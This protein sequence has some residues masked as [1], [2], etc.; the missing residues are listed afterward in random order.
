VLTPG[1][2][3]TVP[4]PTT[5]PLRGIGF[6][7]TGNVPTSLYQLDPNS[8]VNVVIR[9]QNGRQLASSS[10]LTAGVT[11]DTAFQVAL[12]GESI[13]AGTQE[14]ATI[15][16]HG[17]DPLTVDSQGRL[18]S[19]GTVT[20]ATDGL[21]I[22]YVGSTVIYQRMNA[23]PRIR[24]AAQSQTVRGDDN[25]VNL[26]SS[27]KVPA[28]EVVLSAPGPAASGKPGTVRVTADGTD[29]VATKVDAQGAGYLVVADADQV[30]WTAT[31]DGKRADLVAADEGL[32]AV[33]V[34]AG[35]HTVVLEYAV[36]HGRAGAWLSIATAVL[37]IVICVADWLWTRQRRPTLP[38]P[39]H[40]D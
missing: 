37:L 39:T 5:G 19:V 18:P 27:G 13:A 30:G 1:R 29:S 26:L 12:A 40:A 38:S 6:T 33:P 15:T 11:A 22:V 3:V 8:W 34:P 25:R 10:H 16:L 17:P 4:L 24:W 32:V 14:T 7:P 20:D 9:D 28:D 35:Q 36:T 31:V 23:L 2:P 21:K